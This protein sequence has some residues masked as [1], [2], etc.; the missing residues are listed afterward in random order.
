MER[1]KEAREEEER[2]EREGE[3]G[4]GGPPFHILPPHMLN[5]MERMK[6]EEREETTS[7]MNL[8]SERED[9]IRASEGR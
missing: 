3:G 9:K 2:E 6:G 7:P 5:L 4:E 8:S 1:M